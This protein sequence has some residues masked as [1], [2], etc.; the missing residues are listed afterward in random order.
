MC[1]LRCKRCDG[2]PKSLFGRLEARCDVDGPQLPCKPVLAA[3][4]GTQKLSELATYPTKLDCKLLQIAMQYAH[5]RLDHGIH[6]LKAGTV[7]SKMRVR[8]KKG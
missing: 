1:L 8:V 5:E 7:A 2:G 4:I 3:R 6:N